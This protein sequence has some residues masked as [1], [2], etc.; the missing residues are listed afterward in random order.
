MSTGH[1]RDRRRDS[2]ITWRSLDAGAGD[3][4]AAG[5]ALAEGTSHRHAQLVLDRLPR[6]NTSQHASGTA[7]HSVGSCCQPCSCEAVH[8]SSWP[9]MAMTCT[10]RAWL[11]QKVVSLS[12]P[13]SSLCRHARDRWR[14]G[15]RMRRTAHRPSRRRP[16]CGSFAHA[17]SDSYN[18]RVR[19]TNEGPV[20]CTLCLLRPLHVFLNRVSHSRLPTRMLAARRFQ[21]GTLTWQRCLRTA[22]CR[23]A[24]PAAPAWRSA[25]PRCSPALRA[26]QTPSSRTSRSTGAQW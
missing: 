23:P 26:S 7:A 2:R 15:C 24:R 21:A 9:G 6:Q 3:V 16:C 12:T 10:W 4:V 5:A 19:G 13:F 25:R 22:P 1:R 14:Q 20:G 18:L 17:H 8:G 11:Q